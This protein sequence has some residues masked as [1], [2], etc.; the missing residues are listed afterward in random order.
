M[1]V[2]ESI[3][4]LAES[5]S[6]SPDQVLSVV[7]AFKFVYTIVEV[8]VYGFGVYGAAILIHRLRLRH[9]A[10]KEKP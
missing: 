4:Q 3:L 2:V 9:S 8:I 1:S 7:L 5:T 10:R 6:L